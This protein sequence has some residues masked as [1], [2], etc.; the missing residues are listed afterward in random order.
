MNSKLVT[1]LEWLWATRDQDIWMSPS[2]LTELNINYKGGPVL[3]NT[4][5]LS[6]FRFLQKNDL[7][8]PMP[9]TDG[10]NQYIIDKLKDDQW[11][12]TINE[13]KRP[14]WKTN[15]INTFGHLSSP[16]IF[17]LGAIVSPIINDL[18][19]AWVKPHILPKVN[20]QAI[21]QPNAQGQ[22]ND[23]PLIAP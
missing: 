17:L 18:Y 5:S 20:E 19:G 23:Q 7:I 22:Q 14:K 13:L 16:A 9:T 1:V 11:A 15:L 10:K 8:F 4:E 6:V 3:S 12:S 2:V 21:V